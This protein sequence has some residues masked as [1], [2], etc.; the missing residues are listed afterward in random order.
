KQLG[1]DVENRK[2]LYLSEDEQE[3][4]LQELVQ[5]SRMKT[6]KKKQFIYQEGDAP[7][8]VYYVKKGKVRRFLYYLDGRELSTDIHVSGSFF[9]YGAVLL[10]QQYTDNSETLEDTE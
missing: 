8:Y 4:L 6:Y 7:L 1:T 5:R 10:Q 9:G 3:I 2:D